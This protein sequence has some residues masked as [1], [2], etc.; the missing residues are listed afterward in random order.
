MLRAAPAP[1]SRARSRWRPVQ[2][3]HA[4]LA[5][6]GEWCTNDKGLLDRAGLRGIDGI[7][8]SAGGDP[9][10]LAAAVDAAQALFGSVLPD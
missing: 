8:A 2:Q 5:A 10:E 7:L 6:R 3:A 9:D 1:K 4:V